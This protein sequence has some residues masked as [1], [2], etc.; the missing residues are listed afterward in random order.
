M[1][2]K[3]IVFTTSGYTEVLRDRERYRITY[4]TERIRSRLEK[5]KQ[6]FELPVDLEAVKTPAVSGA[7]VF[8]ICYK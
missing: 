3:T 4:E 8:K 5:R 2:Y 7:F 1:N 6:P